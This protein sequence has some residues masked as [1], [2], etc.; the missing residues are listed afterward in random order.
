MSP[1]MVVAITCKLLF[2]CSTVSIFFYKYGSPFLGVAGFVGV[3]GLRFVD[4]L[5]SG[6]GSGCGLVVW[7]ARADEAN[8][9]RVTAY[10]GM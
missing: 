5:D 6:R 8:G 2:Y 9:T 4:L 10:Q 1:M 3:N 7:W